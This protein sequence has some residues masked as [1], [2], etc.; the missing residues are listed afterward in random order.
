MTK[1]RREIAYKYIMLE[2]EKKTWER[3]SMDYKL[4]RKYYGILTANKD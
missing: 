1:K 2:I 4:I 3:N